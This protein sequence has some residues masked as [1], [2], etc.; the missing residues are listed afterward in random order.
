MTD[1]AQMEAIEKE[2][3]DIEE[4]GAWNQVYQVRKQLVAAQ[5]GRERRVGRPDNV[6]TFA[7]DLIFS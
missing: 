6:F 5:E 7:Q 2:Y 1:P 4:S 3:R